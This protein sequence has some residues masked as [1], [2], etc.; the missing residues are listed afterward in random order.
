[1]I[2][3]EVTLPTRAHLYRAITAHIRQLRRDGV[4]VPPELAALTAALGSGTVSS[5]Q[6]WPP[7]AEVEVPRECDPYVVSVREAS[8]RL[9]VSERTVRRLTATGELPSQKIAGRRVYPVDALER[10]LEVAS[11]DQPSRARS[12]GRPDQKPSAGPAAPTGGEG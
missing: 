5:G 10:Y 8:R 1:M 11:P 9:A 12:P 3:L 2:L 4:A 7:V 6:G